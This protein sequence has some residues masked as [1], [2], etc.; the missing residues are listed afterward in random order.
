[1]FVHTITTDVNL[2]GN[3]TYDSDILDLYSG[4]WNTSYMRLHF[5][6]LQDCRGHA[7]KNAGDFVC[8]RV[9]I[10]VAVAITIIFYVA[11]VYSL[12]VALSA[13]HFCLNFPQDMTYA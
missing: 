5:N 1:V 4:R 3:K 10:A 8:E 6:Y 11:A 13:R 9:V 7:E 2:Q 12:I